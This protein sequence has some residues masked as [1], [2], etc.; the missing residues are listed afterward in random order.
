MLEVSKAQW[1][2]GQIGGVRELGRYTD[3]MEMR[4]LVI[5]AK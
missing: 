2:G 1:D 3:S 4:I 5:M